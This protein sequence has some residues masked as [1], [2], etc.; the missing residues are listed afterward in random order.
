VRLSYDGRRLEAI[1]TEGFETLLVHPIP[2]EA[3]EPIPDRIL[4]R[5]AEDEIFPESW[6]GKNGRPAHVQLLRR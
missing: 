5:L 6:I 1:T 4:E 2:G 3:P